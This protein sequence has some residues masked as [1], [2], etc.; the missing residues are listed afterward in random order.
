MS[1]RNRE[2]ALN[3]LIASNISTSPSRVTDE[4]SARQRP[5][6]R[7]LPSHARPGI[8][9]TRPR[10]RR[11]LFGEGMRHHSAHSNFGITR[12]IKPSNSGTVKAVSPCAGA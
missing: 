5:V 6:Y 10:A 1:S 3:E 8:R 7:P 11:H 9:D 4:T 2:I 12:F